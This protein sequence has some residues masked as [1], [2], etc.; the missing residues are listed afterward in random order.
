VQLLV[1]DV[2]GESLLPVH[3]E[4]PVVRPTVDTAALRRTAAAPDRARHW[5]DRLA[6]VGSTP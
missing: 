4:L 6:A 1:D 5:G 3:G 2:V